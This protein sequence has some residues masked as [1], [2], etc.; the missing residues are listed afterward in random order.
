M[1]IVFDS[2]RCRIPQSYV[3]FI[4]CQSVSLN[5]PQAIDC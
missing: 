1:T 5:R 3:S 2:K 4:H